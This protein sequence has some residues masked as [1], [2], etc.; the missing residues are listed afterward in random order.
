MLSQM[1]VPESE[2]S[3]SKSLAVRR[4]KCNMKCTVLMP[5]VAGNLI[6]AARDD[7]KATQLRPRSIAKSSLVMTGLL[8]PESVGTSPHASASTR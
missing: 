1:K 3:V 7:P 5:A 2:V 6:S 8:T 4:S